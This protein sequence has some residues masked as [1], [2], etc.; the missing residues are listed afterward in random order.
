MSDEKITLVAL[1]IQTCKKAD[2][3]ELDQVLY[4]I[5]K[6]G[7]SKDELNFADK[8]GRTALSHICTKSETGFADFLLRFKG[9]DVNK[10]DNDGNTPL[11]FA[12]ETGISDK[13]AML[14]S[15]NRH[16]D[17]DAK[18]SLGL[19]PLMK[20]SI[21]G[22]TDCA[23]RLILANAS[24]S[25]RDPGRGFTARDWAY[26][27]GRKFCGDALGELVKKQKATQLSEKQRKDLKMSLQSLM[28][29]K[30]AATQQQL[31]QPTEV[32]KPVPTITLT[33]PDQSTIVLK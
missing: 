33:S 3:N 22:R 19:T 21:Q 8:N 30:I 23:K 31:Y 12:A 29:T 7:I 17:I 1:L 26:F 18:N 9:I 11:H 25:L 32:K 4:I 28:P 27:C 13:I 24:A 20:A 16:L 10:P 2:K 6:H 5:R 15:R 14:I